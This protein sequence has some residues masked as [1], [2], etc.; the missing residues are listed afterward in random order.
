[1]KKAQKSRK[2]T[3]ASRQIFTTFLTTLLLHYFTV[4]F[5]NSVNSQSET[6]L[7]KTYIFTHQKQPNHTGGAK[8]T[9]PSQPGSKNMPDFDKLNDRIIAEQRTSGPTLVIKTNLDP[10]DST[11]DN[12]YYE[13]NKTTDTKEFRDFFED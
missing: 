11:V 7:L 3:I 6:F 9:E 5:K 8:M 4:Q 12:P 1:M 13:N 10:N 2:P